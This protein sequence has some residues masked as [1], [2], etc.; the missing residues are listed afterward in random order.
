[1][2]DAVRYSISIPLYFEL[3]K[4]RNDQTG[5]ETTLVNGGVLSN[6]PVEIFDC[7]D[8]RDPRWPTFAPH[9]RCDAPAD[10]D[11]NRRPR[12]KLHRAPMRS[13]DG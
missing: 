8:G 4:V 12:P 2:A 6:F 13:A 1:M 7:T 11:R 3:Q 10:P 9:S 5:A